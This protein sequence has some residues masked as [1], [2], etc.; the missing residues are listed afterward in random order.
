MAPWINRYKYMIENPEWIDFTR[1]MQITPPLLNWLRMTKLVIN[2]HML[3]ALEG[4]WEEGVDG[5]IKQINFA[6][7]ANQNT[8]WH[9]STRWTH[10]EYARAAITS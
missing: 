2:Q 1:F 10:R 8:R 9:I 7:R 3:T 5:L 4:N 6:R